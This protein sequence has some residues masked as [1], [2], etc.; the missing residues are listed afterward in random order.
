[1]F[2]E[3]IAVSRRVLLRAAALGALDLGAVCADGQT[4]DRGDS[5]K[6]EIPSAE[7][8]NTNRPLPHRRLG[9]TNLAVTTLGCGGAGITGSEI[10]YRAIE[11]GIDYLDTAPA[12]GH[13]EEVFGEVLA[14]AR[15]RVFLA[16]KWAVMGD[17]T[18][19]RC[20]DSL[21]RSL[22]RLKTDRI[23]LLQLHSVDTGPGLTGTP[24][25]GYIRID[26]PHLHTAMDRAR[27]DGKVRF[28]GVTSHDPQRGTLLKYAIDTG[29]FDTIMVAFN[30]LTYESSGMPQLL[31]HAR[32]HDVGVIGM[33]ASGGDRP[34]GGAA[35]NPLTARLAWMLSQD[36]HTVVH[37]ATVFSVDSQ[38]ACLAAVRTRE[39][40]YGR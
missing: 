7:R 32:K 8:R 30:Y 4:T 26:N 27:K 39:R 36:I 2:A 6:P 16:T 18:V 11:K 1:M 13:S 3:S 15:D 22:R 28:F 21:H 25:D 12:Y 35:A 14:T 37:S 24:R 19:E 33:Q 31:A 40:G 17:W 10:L 20:L 23:D 29:H 5:P 38:D 34:A 9:R